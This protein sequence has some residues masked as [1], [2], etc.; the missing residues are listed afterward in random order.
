[1]KLVYKGFNDF[2]DK[3]AYLLQVYKNLEK[4]LSDRINGIATFSIGRICTDSSDWHSNRDYLEYFVLKELIEKNPDFSA[5]ERVSNDC[6]AANLKG[7]DDGRGFNFEVTSSKTQLEPFLSLF[8]EIYDFL[9][10]EKWAWLIGEDT[11]CHS[12][13]VNIE[14]LHALSFNTRNIIL[15]SERY[16]GL[17]EVPMKHGPLKNYD[18]SIYQT[19]TSKGGFSSIADFCM[20]FPYQFSYAVIDFPHG[21]FQIEP[22]RDRGKGWRLSH[23]DI[24]I[25]TTQV[26]VEFMRA[27]AK[28][29]DKHLLGLEG[30]QQST[31]PALL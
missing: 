24:R 7:C 10:K 3:R 14:H 11:Q 27:V 9:P 28:A 19:F 8:Q 12:N 26:P 4:K 23:Y 6:L 29:T 5:C 25:E 2:V 20:Q 18:S 16:S 21:R 30:N 31:T 15:Q 1:M 13:R 22:V 17:S